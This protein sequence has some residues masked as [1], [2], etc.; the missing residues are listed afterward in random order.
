LFE[1][2][3]IRLIRTNPDFAAALND[4]LVLLDTRAKKAAVRLIAE[5]L[6]MIPDMQV[7]N[8]N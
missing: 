6:D 5:K 2:S 3:V 4:Q 7:E 8:M 1:G